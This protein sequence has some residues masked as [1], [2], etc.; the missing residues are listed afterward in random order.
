MDKLEAAKKALEE[1]RTRAA[2][3][4]RALEDATADDVEELESTFAETE[5][6][7]RKA[8]SE[9]EKQERIASAI[10]AAVPVAPIKVTKEDPTYTAARARMDGLSFFRDLITAKNDTKAAG[11]LERARKEYLETRVDGDST[12][13]YGGYF[14]P[15]LYMGELWAELPRAGRPFAD[16]LPKLPLPDVGNTITIPRVTTGSA[17]AEQTA[18]TVGVT[19]TTLQASEVTSSLVTISGKNDYSRQAI[20]RTFPGLDQIIFSDLSRAYNAELD[21]QALGG[22]GSS[23]Q[24]LGLRNVGSI[25]SLTYTDASPSQAKVVGQILNAVQTVYT[26]RFMQPDLIVMHPRRAAWLADPNANTNFSLFQQGPMFH[27]VGEMDKGFVG[28]ISGIP[29]LID[30]NVT[31]TQGA[32][33]NQDEIYVVYS[34]DFVLFEGDV[35]QVAYE[36]VLSANLEIRLMVWA[37]SFLVLGREPTAICKIGGT[38]LVA[39]TF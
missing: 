26:N 16:K 21:S 38:G 12:T 4:A 39:P 36:E 7:V 31:T 18:D 17:V 22:S 6:E 20:E 11:R 27:A 9:V 33:T 8:E 28:S 1:A 25:G 35:N 34:P 14:I 19:Q 3:A 24:H 32:S 23:G 30:P 10:K 13:T 37:Y 29:V 2:D 5:D 15:P